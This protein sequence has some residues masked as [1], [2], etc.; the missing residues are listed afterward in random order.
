MMI[1]VRYN[2][3]ILFSDVKHKMREFV[4]SENHRLN[5]KIMN[6]ETIIKELE[7]KLSDKEEKVVVPTEVKAEVV[8]TVKQVC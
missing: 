7:Q 1:Y 8:E 2:K 4:Q 6:L 3:C 5:D